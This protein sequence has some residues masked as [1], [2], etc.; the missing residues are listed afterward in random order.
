VVLGHNPLLALGKPVE[1]STFEYL[2]QHQLHQKVLLALSEEHQQKMLTV[3]AR[4][5]GTSAPR[6]LLEG[7]F[8]L[9]RSAVAGKM[10]KLNCKWLGPYVVFDRVDPMAP[11]VHILDLSTRRVR[12]AHLQDLIVFDMARTTVMEAERLAAVDTFEYQ[13]E[14]ILDHKCNTSRKDKKSDYWFLVKWLNYDETTWEPFENVKTNVL[15]TKYAN[16]ISLK[17]FMNKP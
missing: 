14:K 9:L 6:M 15:V 4:A 12:E 13:V 8:V 10:T 1:G 5:Q 17:M 2:A 7:E 3:A 11:L 16:E